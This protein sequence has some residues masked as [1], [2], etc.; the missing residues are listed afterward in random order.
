MKTGTNNGFDGQE[1]QFLAAVTLAGTILLGAVIAL[2]FPGWPYLVGTVA[3]LVTG[4]LFGFWITP[5]L[6]HEWRTMEEYRALRWDRFLGRIWIALWQPYAKV[7]KHRSKWTHSWVGTL[8][9]AIPF[10]VAIIV[11]WWLIRSAIGLPAVK[12]SGFY[13]T[14]LIG[15][16]IQ[17]SVHYKHDGLG[18]TGVWDD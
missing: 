6:D 12:F 1:H 8:I 15:W 17:D 7:F 16:L 9:R 2:L 10:L 5:D 14:F 11:P 4:S 13:L 3:G 18:W